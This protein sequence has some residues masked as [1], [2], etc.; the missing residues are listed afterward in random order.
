MQTIQMV[1]S[2]ASGRNGG[3]NETK[4]VNFNPSEGDLCIHT[5]AGSSII[6]I[7]D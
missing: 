5:S 2:S 7:I 6:V 1:V 3:K 4:E